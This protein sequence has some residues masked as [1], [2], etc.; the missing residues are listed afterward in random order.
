MSATKEVKVLL[1][2]LR[3]QLDPDQAAHLEPTLRKILEAAKPKTVSEVVY[4]SD[5]NDIKEIEALRAQLHAQDETVRSL[6]FKLAAQPPL[7]DHM[8]F[9]EMVREWDNRGRA[10]S[11]CTITCMKLMSR[12]DAYR[13][14]KQTALDRCLRLSL[15]GLLNYLTLFEGCDRLDPAKLR[16]MVDQQSTEALQR[17]AR[18]IHAAAG[19]TV[20]LSLL[21][22]DNLPPREDA[23]SVEPTVVFVGTGGQAPKPATG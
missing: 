8:S 17:L 7:L 21:P 14:R 19:I 15:V 6:R 12:S 2:D 4:R 23:V 20:N 18:D 9:D 1:E 22:L 10:W 11:E 3:R 13:G 5:P 16:K